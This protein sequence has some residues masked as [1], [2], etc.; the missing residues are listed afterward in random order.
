[1]ER[2]L[3]KQV[4][5]Y[6][7]KDSSI[8]NSILSLLNPNLGIDTLTDLVSPILKESYERKLEYLYEINPVVRVCMILEDINEELKI[9]EFE[10]M[11]E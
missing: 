3:I 5:Y 9:V 10:S 6:I 7:D 1:M 4:E 2:S 8:S 11:I